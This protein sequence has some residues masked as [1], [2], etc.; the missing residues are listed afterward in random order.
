MTFAAAVLTE[1]ELYVR[2]VVETLDGCSWSCWSEIARGYSQKETVMVKCTD[3][4]LQKAHQHIFSILMITAL[5][6]FLTSGEK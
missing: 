1:V 4:S 6:G 2:E 5:F 3:M